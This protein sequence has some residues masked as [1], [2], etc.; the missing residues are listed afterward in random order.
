MVTVVTTYKYNDFKVKN[1]FESNLK[2]DMLRKGF[3]LPTKIGKNSLHFLLEKIGIKKNSKFLYFYDENLFNAH[4]ST[5]DK[6]IKRQ[7]IKTLL[8]ISNYRGK[9]HKNNLPVR[10]QR[11]HT[12]A[13]TRR[14]RA[15]V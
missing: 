15:V 13:K 5:L 14:K 1:F 8:L 7:S 9:R 10:G 3:K 2:Q 11:T 12:N 6:I 4:K